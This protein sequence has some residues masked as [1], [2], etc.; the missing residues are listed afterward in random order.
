[1]SSGTPLGLEERLRLRREIEAIR[2]EL[3]RLILD[4]VR[5]IA[6]RKELVLRIGELK[7]KLGL[8][9][10]DEQREAQVVEVGIR[11]SKEMGVD[12]DVVEA[13]LRSLME[14]GRRLQE[15]AFSN[16]DTLRP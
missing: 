5:L 8:G 9:V 3:D 12:P 13:V 15:E 6:R 16:K 11:A 2:Q 10:E 4:L 7:A 1:M 14:Y